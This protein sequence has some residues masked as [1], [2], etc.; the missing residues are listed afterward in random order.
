MVVPHVLVAFGIVRAALD[1]APDRIAVLDAFA[2]QFLPVSWTGSRATIIENRRALLRR[3]FT[4]QDAREVVWARE[5][6]SRLSVL[7]EQ[8][9]AY[10]SQRQQRFE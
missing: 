4:S 10:E 9:R 8:E 2:S 7:A 1:A 6:D 3:F 5:K